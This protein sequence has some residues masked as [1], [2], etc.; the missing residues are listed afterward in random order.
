[1]ASTDVVG[2]GLV[3]PSVDVN[4]VMLIYVFPHR[5]LL[6]VEAGVMG[7]TLGVVGFVTTALTL[8]GT[9]PL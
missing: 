5:T 8:K 2:P 6:L 9:P 1:M 4:D 3:F 7:N